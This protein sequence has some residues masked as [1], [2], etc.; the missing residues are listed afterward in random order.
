MLAYFCKLAA[1]MIKVENRPIEHHN[2]RLS[3]CKPTANLPSLSKGEFTGATW[4]F[5]SHY[6]L[7][8]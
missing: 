8:L 4:L 5:M 7:Y 6:V 2:G 1:R 3:H